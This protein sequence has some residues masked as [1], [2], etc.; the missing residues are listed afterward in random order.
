[1]EGV[2]FPSWVRAQPRPLCTLLGSPLLQS[3]GCLRAV[4]FDRR[5]IDFPGL[6]E[7]AV[8]W[9]HGER[10]LLYAAW[11]L[12]NGGDRR[13]FADLLDGELLAEAIDTLSGA[14]LRRL[15]EAVPLRRPDVDQP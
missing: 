8:P 4:D 9:S 5:R 11:T 1:L 10:I 13:A 12:F 2:E 14:N 3:K 15:I 7:M 6:G